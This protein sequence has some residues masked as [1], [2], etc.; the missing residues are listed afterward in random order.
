[1]NH[2]SIAQV[3]DAGVTADGRPYFA[4]EYVPGIPIT[5][6]CDKHRLSI[7]DRLQL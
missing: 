5:D 2:V 7:D 3:Y 1:M 6:Y 4:M